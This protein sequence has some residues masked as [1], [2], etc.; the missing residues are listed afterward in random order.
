MSL[1]LIQNITACRPGL[2]IPFGAAGGTPPYV[3]SLA[4]LGAGGTIDASTGLYTAPATAPVSPANP[5]DRVIV[6][7]AALATSTGNI[8]IGDPLVLFC[9]VLARQAG[10]ASNRVWIYNQKINEPTDS[11]PYIVVQILSVK[12]FGNSCRMDDDG[13]ELR[14]ANL[15]IM[16]SLDIKSRSINAMAVRDKLVYGLVGQYPES[17]QELN[18]FYISPLISN[19]LNLGELDGA[20]IPYRYNATAS[21]QYAVSNLAAVPYFGTFN[22]PVIVTND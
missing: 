22:D 4:A 3:Y 19:M 6:T 2:A 7:D 1:A 20:A 8:L 17:Q 21:L 10:L 16:L 18:S 15:H 9:E 5:I 14:T 13:N 12:P 11:N